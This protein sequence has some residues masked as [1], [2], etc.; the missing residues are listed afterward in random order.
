MTAFI[1][2]Q[3]YF[4]VKTDIPDEPEAKAELAKKLMRFNVSLLEYAQVLKQD[5]IR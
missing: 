4:F 5:E 3:E 1:V 2:H